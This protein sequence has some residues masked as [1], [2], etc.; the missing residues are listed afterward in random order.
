MPD[1]LWNEVRDI[2]QETGIKTIPRKKKCKKAKWLPEEALQIAVKRREVKSKGE[3]ERYFHLNAEF[4]R[5]A[6]RDKKAFLSDQCKEIEENN[7]M[8]KTRDLF[9]KIRDTKGTFQA[10]MG[11]IKDRNAMDLTEGDDIKKRWQEYTGELYKKDLHDPDNHDGVI[12]HLQPD[13]LECEVKWASGSITANKASGSDGIP[14][15][16]FQILTDDAV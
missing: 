5:I 1:E 3:K 10:K 7:R 12:T 11:T 4:Q 14:V 9:K 8:G 16:P 13:I 15:E 6:S 2:V